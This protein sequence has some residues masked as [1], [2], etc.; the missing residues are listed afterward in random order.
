[1][2]SG[3]EQGC[4]ASH[5]AALRAFLDSDAA[6]ALV[7]E[8]DVSAIDGDAIEGIASDIEARPGWGVAHLSR[9]VLGFRSAWGTSGDMRLYRAHLFPMT[10]AALLWSRDGAEGFLA[11]GPDW[12]MDHAL[13]HWALGARMGIGFDRPLVDTHPFAS[14]IL[15]REAL[16]DASYERHR[17]RLRLRQKAQATWN[18]A[19]W[20]FT[21]R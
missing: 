2:T 17:A 1:M 10:T 4:R 6:L 18:R 15:D 7:L 3:A 11:N 20:R 9:P 13:R 12:P 19:R 21:A 16:I 8:D 14:E 5:E